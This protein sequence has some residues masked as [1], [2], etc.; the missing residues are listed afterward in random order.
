MNQRRVNMYWQL[1][2]STQQQYNFPINVAVVCRHIARYTRTMYTILYFLMLDIL[3]PGH[4]I[5]LHF[6]QFFERCQVIVQFSH[7]IVK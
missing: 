1:I 7:Y 3:S 4:N 6:T 5:L 2:I